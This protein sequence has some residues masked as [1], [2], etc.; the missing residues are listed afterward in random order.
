VTDLALSENHGRTALVQPG[1][2]A[3]S[4]GDRVVSNTDLS[5]AQ[6]SQ[7]RR[8]TNLN[9]DLNGDGVVNSSNTTLVRFQMGKRV[10]ASLKLDD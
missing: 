3:N 9:S 2:A 6:S 7:G 8:G 10:A 5:I 4:N 1:N